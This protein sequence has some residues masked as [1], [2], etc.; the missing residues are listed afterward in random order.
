MTARTLGVELYLNLE[1][2][3]AKKFYLTFAASSMV[4]LITNDSYYGGE[5]G[6]SN[7]LTR[8]DATIGLW[9]YFEPD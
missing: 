4:A 1:L 6:G 5:S 7:N 2:R 3:L 9:Y 8:A